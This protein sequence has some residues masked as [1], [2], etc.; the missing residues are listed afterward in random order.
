VQR[1]SLLRNNQDA[2]LASRRRWSQGV[3]REERGTK[4]SSSNKEDQGPY[5][6]S[7]SQTI[8]AFRSGRTI[9]WE[10]DVK[11]ELDLNK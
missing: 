3:E 5:D 8:T 11:M 7:R 4:T 10:V 2:E 9:R 1:R 6:R